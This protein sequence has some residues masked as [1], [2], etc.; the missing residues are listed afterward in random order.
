M[1]ETAKI[2]NPE[3]TVVLPDEHAGCPLA[4]SA[5]YDEFVQ[6]RREN[7]DHIAVTYI[8]S[9]TEVK[10]V[11]DIICTSSSVKR[12]VEAIPASVPVLFA[13]DKNLGTY[14]E[15]QLGR[16]MLMWPGGCVVHLRFD[17]ALILHVKKEQP[18]SVIAAHPECDA[19]VLALAD[20]IGS[21]SA[22][23][24]YAVGCNAS[25]II[26][27]TE[28]GIIHQMKKANPDK[29]YIPA[30][31]ERLHGG[32]ICVN[33]KKNTIGKLRA[34]LETGAPE[35]RI[36]EPLRRAAELPIRRML[37]LGS[38]DPSAARQI[39]EEIQLPFREESLN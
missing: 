4:D 27:A 30:P 19:D 10:A 32:S 9:S 12:I 2:I 20:F 25:T 37:Q 39:I 5:P 38:A 18:D 16:N 31:A 22:I 33:M 3:K 15:R 8:N 7:P 11:S 17:P 14:I 21:T 36:D 13:P 24:E 29:T 28:P 26:V 1:A 34:C 35:I 23:L 6:F